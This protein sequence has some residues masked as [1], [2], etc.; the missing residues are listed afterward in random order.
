M[1][2]FC[3]YCAEE[4]WGEEIKPDIDIFEIAKDLQPN[5]YQPVLC[6]GCG[7]AAVGVNDKGGIWIAT[8][9]AELGEQIV[10]WKEFDEWK[11]TAG[12]RHG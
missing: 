6:E 7:M 9:E 10:E 4:M 5:T 3:N 2:E 8:R 1:A 12:L 11:R